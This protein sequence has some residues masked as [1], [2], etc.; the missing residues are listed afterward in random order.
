[1]VTTDLPDLALAAEN[2]V[3]SG[4]DLAG[5]LLQ[6]SV[7]V[8]NVGSISADNVAVRLSLGDPQRGGVAIDGE[9]IIPTLAPGESQ[10]VT[11]AWSTPSAGGTNYLYLRVDPDNLLS[12]ANEGN[13]LAL[14]RVE[15]R[16]A[17]APDLELTANDLR[18]APT[19]PVEGET[20]TVTATVYNRGVSVG[21]IKVALFDGDPAQ[22]GLR[23]GETVVAPRLAT[24]A[25]ATVTFALDTLNWSGTHTLFVVIDPDHALLEENEGN[26]RANRAVTVLPA[27][28]QLTV[29]TSQS[30]Y[31]ARSVIPITL[32]VLDQAPIGRTLTWEVRIEEASGLPAASVGSG[33][34]T[35]L[36]NGVA[37]PLAVTGQTGTLTSGAY[38]LVAWLRDGNRVAARA[39]VPLTI[40]ADKTLRVA[41]SSDKP[42]YAANDVAELTAT[43]TSASANYFFGGLHLVIDVIDPQGAKV[44]SSERIPPVLMPGQTVTLKAAWNTTAQP[45]GNYSLQLRAIDGSDTLAT[46][47]THVEILGSATT[48]AG[49]GGTLSAVP[50]VVEFGSDGQL[51]FVVRNQG[52]EALQG[53]VSVLLVHPET[54]QTL[55]TLTLA[56]PVLLAV[57][58]TYAGQLTYTADLGVNTYLAV[59][60]FSGS[61]GATSL[62]GTP[63]RIKDETPPHLSVLS[64]LAGTVFGPQLDFS[65]Q[66]EDR[67]SGL[68]QVD[69]RIDDGA[70][71]TLTAETAPLGR[72]REQRPALPT[73]NGEHSVTFRAVDGA[74]NAAESGAIPFTVVLDNQPPVTTLTLG[75]MQR[76]TDSGELLTD[77][78]TTLT[79]TSSDEGTGVAATFC[80]FDTEPADQ[81]CPGTLSLE[82]L[83]PGAHRFHY[84]SVDQAGNVEAEQGLDL[85]RID[86]T[87]TTT[88]LAHA[89]VLVWTEESATN[90]GKQSAPT[91][92]EVRALL[93]EAFADP[94][95]YY[96]VVTDKDVFRQAVRSGIYTVVMILRQ[97]VPLDANFQRELREV[98]GGGVGLLIA[99]W[100]NSVPP[101][102]QDVFGVDFKGSLAM[103]EASRPLHFYAGALSEEQGATAVGRVLR[104]PL[105]GGTLAGILPAD[106]ICEGVRSVTLVQP[107]TLLAGDRVAATLEAV[108][109]KRITP[110]DSEI[111]TLAEL[112]AGPMNRSPGNL[113]GDLTLTGTAADGLTLS[114]SAPVGTVLGDSYRVTVTVTR[115]DG[116]STTTT[117][118]ITPTCAAHLRPGMTLGDARLIGVD[119]E[120]VKSGEDLPAVVLGQYRG[121]RTVFLAYDPLLSAWSTGEN[122]HLDLLRRAAPWLAPAAG[123]IA[124]SGIALLETTVALAG[125]TLD[126]TA[127]DTLGTGLTHLPLYDL[128]QTPLTYRFR[129]TDGD[130]AS[131]RYFVRLPDQAGDYQK[132]T[133]LSM[134]LGGSAVPYAHYMQ[135]FTLA[136]DSANLLQ[137][138]VFLVE[139]LE[140]QHPQAV[141]ALAGI[142]VALKALAL[143][144]RTTAADFDVII[145]AVLQ[146]LQS[147][148]QLPFDTEELQTIL[149]RYLRI[150]EARQV[151]G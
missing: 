24:G 103:D 101:L 113:S 6:V 36:G 42:A 131:Y 75:G 97:D 90:G 12:E 45:K 130:V 125:A 14:T 70:W 52:N 68:A 51:T 124:P 100:K 140:I 43:V 83:A 60:R 23:R 29:A 102:W 47:V 84:H 58:A 28:V 39:A 71:H 3:I 16:P 99:H 126:L 18:I 106:S 17:Q 57:D 142:D 147:V 80:G 121:G 55:R 21:D 56:Q 88:L 119:E 117:L 50:A 2:V 138:A 37:M 74:G 95:L 26:N 110:V 135:V 145:A 46:A 123:E 120:R 148:E 65:V 105:A 63:L 67:A 91:P 150:I 13:N 146:I 116:G 78:T 151:A 93:A 53:N 87:V 76:R 98:V 33:S 35:T 111:A 82:A 133:E 137:Q 104:T 73:E 40:L 38:Q 31:A 94:D 149:G 22:G 54:Q 86:L 41:L 107:L 92:E 108:A 7:P 139:E 143:L 109:N 49:V 129:L 27:N 132:E 11:F 44:L 144:P 1:V 141:T 34:V 59:L 81:P 118:P 8:R 69:Y 114:L 10:P 85:T 32:T 25:S 115:A 62:A 30:A 48:L 4:G 61:S 136:T 122:V 112:S 66:A 89:R 64:P 19:A 15:L 134:D 9:R 96:T 77:A 128:T 127:V 72:Y 20:L 5:S 79:L